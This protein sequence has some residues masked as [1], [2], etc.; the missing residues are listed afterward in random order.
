MFAIDVYQVVVMVERAW[1]VRVTSSTI[2]NCWNH[3][4]IFSVLVEWETNQARRVAEVDKLATLLHQLTLLSSDIEVSDTMNAQEYLNY[5]LEFDLNNPYEPTDDEFLGM[6][7]SEHQEPDVDE[8][9]VDVVEEVVGLNVAERSLENLKK[10]FQ[11]RPFDVL[12]HIKSIEGL[13]KEY[14][15]SLGLFKVLFL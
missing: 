1:R 11:Q 6:F 12:S 8:V 9:I 14:I 7:P 15:F 5:E 10:Y 3:T 13:Q 4:G 2:Q